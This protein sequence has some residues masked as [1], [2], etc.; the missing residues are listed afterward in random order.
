M[1][2]ILN[3]VEY[4][5]YL[6]TKAKLQEAEVRITTLNKIHDE[7]SSKIASL[8]KRM[9][10]LQYQLQSAENKAHKLGLENDELRKPIVVGHLNDDGTITRYD[11]IGSPAK[12]V[13]RTYK[14]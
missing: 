7:L 10:D 8:N 11:G 4:Q 14:K 6:A 13:L 2:I 12:T 5:E 1:Q 3:E 9:F